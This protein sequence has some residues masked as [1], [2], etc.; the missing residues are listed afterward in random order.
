MNLLE[1]THLGGSRTR[2]HTRQPDLNPYFLNHSGLSLQTAY[3]EHLKVCNMLALILVHLT[4]VG[5][6]AGLA[7]SIYCG[8]RY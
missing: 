8:R 4:F 1:D 3:L 6:E 2:I 5:V 7:L